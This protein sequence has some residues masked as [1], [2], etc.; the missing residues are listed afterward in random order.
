MGSLKRNIF[1]NSLLTTAN[2]IFPLITFPYISRVLGVTNIGICNFVDSIINYYS[3]FAM[4]GIRIVAIREIAGV[5]NDPKNLSKVFSSLLTLNLISTGILVAALVLSTV[6]IPSFHA[7]QNM[8]FIGVAK[9]IFTALLVEWFYNGIEDFQYITVR[10]IVVR[11]LYVV[12]IFV[13]VKDADDYPIYYGLLTLTIVLNALINVIHSR[14]FVSFSFD[15]ISI[16]KYVKPFFILGF[17]SLLTSLYTTFNTMF[18]GFIGGPTEVGYYTTATKLHQIILAL[19][20]AFTGVMMPRMSSLFSERKESELQSLINKSIR[21]IFTFSFPM[22]CFFSIFADQV[23]LWMSGTGYE[24]AIPCM[25]IIIPLIFIVGYEQILVFQILMPLKKDRY[26]LINSI[27]GASVGILAN[28]ILVPHLV[29]IGSSIVWFISE[30]SIFIC[31]L[32]FVR[33]SSGIRFSTDQFIKYALIS[34]PLVLLLFF[35][36]FWNP[37]GQYTLF[38][39]ILIT[40]VYFIIVEFLLFKNEMLIGF[41]KNRW[42]TIGRR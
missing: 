8:M 31:A 28:I 3:L 23:I 10:S 39:G 25:R 36:H 1:Y 17:Y 42:L 38:L 5:K 29:S 19:F 30:L 7:H 32:I 37:L 35:T 24:K 16:K 9:L 40:A 22:I 34:I 4:M 21:I 41:V 13:F 12:L 33:K 20:T 15:G 18:L 26:V 14:K 27:V 2:Y 11:L 6:F